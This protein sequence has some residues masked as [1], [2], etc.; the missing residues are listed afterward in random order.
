MKRHLAYT[1]IFSTAI[2]FA[3]TRLIADNSH[4]ISADDVR[5]LSERKNTALGLNPL[6]PAGTLTGADGG[7]G[8]G[9]G[10][11]SPTGSGLTPP[12]PPQAGNGQLGQGAQAKGSGIN[13]ALKQYQDQLNKGLESVQQ[14]AANAAASDGNTLQEIAALAKQLSGSGTS[15]L[16]E[17]LAPIMAEIENTLVNIGAKNTEL[18]TIAMGAS[19]MVQSIQP[20]PA[21][22]TA[23]TQSSGPTSRASSPVGQAMELG[24]AQL[25]NSS[26][27]S[28]RK[29]LGLVGEQNSSKAYNPP[30][31]R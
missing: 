13:D 25:Q 4:G 7:G 6:A 2:F 27:S 17:Q 1:F 14:A 31:H 9:G 12:T 10:G 22:Q 19:G 18:A 21:V 23:S 3:D 20:K 29:S 26:K 24:E 15:N 11:G 8:G 30:G 16:A 28:L 5:A